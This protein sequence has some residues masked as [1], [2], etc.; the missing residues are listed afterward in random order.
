MGFRGITLTILFALMTGCAA[1]ERSTIPDRTY[2]NSYSFYD[3]MISWETTSDN[4]GVTISGTMKNQ[5][6]YYLSDPELTAALLNVDGKIF[7]E[8]TFFFFP[9]QLALDEIAPFTIRIPVKEGQLPYRIRFT[10][11]Y[12][13]AEEGWFGSPRF[14]SFETKP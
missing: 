4:G 2:H 6:Y 5:S 14:H 8:G 7:A 10:Y 13:L 3:L 11:R 9:H 1:A 12:R